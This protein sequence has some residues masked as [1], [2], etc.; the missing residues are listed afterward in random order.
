[1]HRSV[2]LIKEVDMQVE[3]TGKEH[4]KLYLLVHPLKFLQNYIHK[5]KFK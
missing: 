1:M 4:G 2:K 5:I 3:G